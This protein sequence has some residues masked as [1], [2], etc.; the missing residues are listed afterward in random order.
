MRTARR[1]AIDSER[2]VARASSPRPIDILVWISLYERTGS[3]PTAPKNPV[4]SGYVVEASHF[5]A[6]LDLNFRPYV[7]VTVPGGTPG[8]IRVNVR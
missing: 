2:A 4:S 3:R 5:V 6:A 1:L 7:E 8:D